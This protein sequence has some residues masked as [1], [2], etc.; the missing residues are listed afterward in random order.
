MGTKQFLCATL[1]ALTAC[2]A[3]QSEQ[4][5]AITLYKSFLFGRKIINC[6]FC[7]RISD[8]SHANGLKRIY[9]WIYRAGG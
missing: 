6:Y 2:S 8:N 5:H 7:M 3:P 1:L 9:N 4:A